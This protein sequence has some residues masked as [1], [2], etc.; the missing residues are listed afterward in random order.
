MKVRRAVISASLIN[1][2]SK[3]AAWILSVY[4]ASFFLSERGD[5]AFA[6][7]AII[8]SG[9]LVGCLLDLGAS[10]A[11]LEYSASLA[12]GEVVLKRVFAVCLRRTIQGILVGAIAMFGGLVIGFL[13]IDV[14]QINFGLLMALA[15]SCLFSGF[16]QIVGLLQKIQSLEL[17]DYRVTLSSL[18]ASILATLIVAYLVVNTE[19]KSEYLALVYVAGG[20]IF[21]FVLAAVFIGWKRLCSLFLSFYARTVEAIGMEQDLANYGIRFSFVSVTSVV[22]NA[23]DVILIGGIL[24]SSDVSRYSVGYRLFIGVQAAQLSVNQLW[25]II[26]SRWS[27][28]RH[29][30]RMKMIALLYGI[31]LL[32][33]SVMAGIALC[34]TNGFGLIP[35]LGVVSFTRAELWGFFLFS[36][37]SGVG[38]I[39]SM[40][41]YRSNLIGGLIKIQLIWCVCMVVLK[42][43]AGS[44]F[45]LVG[46]IWTIV[47]VNYF[48]FHAPIVFHLFRS[49][50]IAL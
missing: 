44:Y 7:F 22:G 13:Y 26:A 39:S 20:V 34:I 4:L 23:L 30:D 18:L 50:N 37:S 47:F 35:G 15:V 14:V 11:F 12:G 28:G 19:V 33:A 42:L 9:A 45:G 27:S 32:L 16:G 8:Q 43:I 36:V 46:F 24:A 48:L 49:K 5:D 25:P 1:A 10:A 6:I 3:A 38:G 2:A 29:A 17:R 21:Q 40:L 31:S 41:A